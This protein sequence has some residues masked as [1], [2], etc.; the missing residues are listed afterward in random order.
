MLKN[1]YSEDP[2]AA[3]QFRTW[4]YVYKNNSALPAFKDV[5]SGNYYVQVKDIERT[6]YD[7]D[8]PRA[9]PVKKQNSKDII[10]LTDLMNAKP[11]DKTGE[12]NGFDTLKIADIEDHDNT[13]YVE[14]EKDGTSKFDR[15]VDDKQ[16]VEVPVIKKEMDEQQKEQDKIVAENEEK[17]IK[18]DPLKETAEKLEKDLSSKTTEDSDKP[19]KIDLSLKKFDDE[20]IM[21]A[22]ESHSLRKRVSILYLNYSNYLHLCNTCL[23]ANIWWETY[24]I[25]SISMCN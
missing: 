20:E 13:K 8:A 21:H 11:I 3:P 9:E 14:V 10:E 16:Y 4:F 23:V 12:I 6:T 5:I 15:V 18:V 1:L 22:V 7:F 24:I 17:L 25:H 2:T 19:E